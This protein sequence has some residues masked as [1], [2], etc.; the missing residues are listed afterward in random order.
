M[1]F[2]APTG[3][4]QWRIDWIATLKCLKIDQD[5]HLVISVPGLLQI[6]PSC[7]A[8]DDEVAGYLR[9]HV[10]WILHSRIHSWAKLCNARPAPEALTRTDSGERRCN[11][12]RG[13][14]RWASMTS[15]CVH[16]TV[17]VSAHLQW[18]V[19]GEG[20]EVLQFV[21]VFVSWWSSFCRGMA[22]GDLG[23]EERSGWLAGRLEPSLTGLN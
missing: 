1:L 11:W 14:Y 9:Q 13:Y 18:R 2:Y 23:W 12:G 5:I 10:G 22:G 3:V 6:I 19:F 21:L 15:R 4:W 20:K 8:A 17:H 7:P 16:A